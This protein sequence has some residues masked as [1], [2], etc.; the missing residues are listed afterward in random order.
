M[1]ML[2][3]GRRIAISLI[4]GLVGIICLNLPADVSTPTT[5]PTG[6]L[7]DDAQSQVVHTVLAKA[8]N[9]FMLHNGFSDTWQY[10]QFQPAGSGGGDHSFKS[11][12]DL[13]NA[14][15]QL[16]I[17]WRLKFNAEF[18][19]GSDIQ[20]TV[21]NDGFDVFRGSQGDSVILA[22]ERI[23]PGDSAAAPNDDSN[24]T[25]PED[26]Q[27]SV[28]VAAAGGISPSTINLANSDDSPSVWKIVLPAGDTQDSLHDSLLRHLNTLHDEKSNWPDDQNEAYRV[29]SREILSALSEPPPPSV[30]DGN[31]D[32][33]S[34]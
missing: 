25:P 5:R 22:S 13:N 11:Y 31:S 19:I 34:P 27:A 18:E 33:G 6:P 21:F 10:F 9:T 15:D 28:Y 14:V 16:R 1:G 29:V 32:N 4:V 20:A 8:I 17:D 24:V 26:H 30:P 12:D 3:Q 23:K 7:A 2:F